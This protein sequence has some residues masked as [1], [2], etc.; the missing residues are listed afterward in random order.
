MKEGG[1]VVLG[2]IFEKNF[3]SKKIE[4]I[5][6]ILSRRLSFYLLS[7]HLFFFVLLNFIIFD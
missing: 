6:S 2:Q 7:H 4:I 3:S 5:I 1:G